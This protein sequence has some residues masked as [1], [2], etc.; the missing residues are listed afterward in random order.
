MNFVA[1]LRKLTKD[2]KFYDS[3]DALLNRIVYELK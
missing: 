3:E 2:S 1:E